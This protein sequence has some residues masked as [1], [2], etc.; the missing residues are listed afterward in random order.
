MQ[1]T[2]LTI[3]RKPKPLA[4]HLRLRHFILVHGLR[5][6]AM[7]YRWQ[8]YGTHSTPINVVTKLRFDISVVP[9]LLSITF[10]SVFV[11]VSLEGFRG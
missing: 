1:N 7:R 3:R 10:V 6:Y 8:L 4:L 5:S 9:P 2:N 11:C